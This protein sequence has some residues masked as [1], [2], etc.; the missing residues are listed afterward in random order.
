M[1]APHHHLLNRRVL[2][3]GATGFIGRH[4]CAA[5]QQSGAVVLATSRSATEGSLREVRSLP[6]DITDAGFVA[7]LVAKNQPEYVFHL[8]ALK[9]RSQGMADFRLAADTNF[10]ATV[11]LAI[12]CQAIPCF[13][14][15][16]ALGTCEEYGPAGTPFREDAR[17]MPANSY[18]ASKLAAT[19][20]LQTMHRASGFPSVILRPSLAYG[21][22]Q[23]DDMMLPALIRSL[24]AGRRFPMTPG[25]Q[26]RDYVFVDD[27]VQ[28]ILLASGNPSV[29]GQVM[30]V[31]SGEPVTLR[32]IAEQVAALVGS[33]AAELLDFGVFDY[34]PGEALSYWADPAAIQSKLG[35]RLFTGL[36]E[37]LGRTVDFYRAQS[38]VVDVNAS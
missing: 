10:F 3:T 4:L 11:N 20:F 6:G 27:L 25:A 18:A 13:R 16:V 9:K 2:V 12:A 21:P 31:G 1:I 17:E 33:E 29:C 26:T 34:R 7:Q 8:A 30:N 22:G 28:A 36:Q 19:Y 35:W 14:Q 38:V 15:M 37:G 32:T 23:G 5:L 24:L